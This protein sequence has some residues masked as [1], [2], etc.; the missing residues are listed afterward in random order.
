M[1]ALS[2]EAARL[3]ATRL[4]A[5]RAESQGAR[6]RE[7]EARAA[8]LIVRRPITQQ[9]HGDTEIGLEIIPQKESHAGARRRERQA[10]AQTVPMVPDRAGVTQGVELVAAPVAEVELLVEAQLERA[11]KAVVAADLGCAI[12]PGESCAAE[13]NRGRDAVWLAADNLGDQASVSV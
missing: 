5:F 7:Q 6:E 8:A 1:Q 13:V 11:S 10:V 3:R 2:P 4:A 12:A 9:R